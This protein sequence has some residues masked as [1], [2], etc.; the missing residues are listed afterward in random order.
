MIDIAY[1]GWLAATRKSAPAVSRDNEI[2]EWL[3]RL[4]S[5]SAII[6]EV[7]SNRVCDEPAPFGI[8]C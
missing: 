8:F 4:I 3:R 1:S 6:E 5:E 7:S 2:D